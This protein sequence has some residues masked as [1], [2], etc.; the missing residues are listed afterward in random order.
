MQDLK[1]NNVIRFTNISQKKQV[2][3]ANFKVKGIKNG[4]TFTASISVDLSVLELH[5]GDSIEKIVEECAK[6]AVQQ[7]KSANFQ[8][9]GLEKLSEQYLG[10]AQLG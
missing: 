6:H 2:L 9:E 10:V 5:S 3:L 8:F 4:V 1:E 7:F